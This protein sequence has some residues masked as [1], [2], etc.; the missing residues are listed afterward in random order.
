MPSDHLQP[1]AMDYDV[2]VV[3]AGFGGMYMLHRLREQGFSVRV[4][5]AGTGV[6]GT[7]YWN[8]YPGARC[9]VE[10]LAYQYNFS[11]DLRQ[12]WQWTERYATQQEILR[13]ANHVADRFDLS[14]HMQFETRILSARYADDSNGW[15]LETEHGDRFSAR[16]VVTA[17]GCL[18]AARIPDFPGLED[19]RGEWYHTGWWPHEEVDF[20]GKRVGIIGTGSSA[21]QSIPVIA[22][23]AETLTV[24]QR[25][26]NFSVPAQNV[27]LSADQRATGSQHD[28]RPTHQIDFGEALL[29]QL[30]SARAASPAER[31]Q[32]YETY[33][34]QGGPGFMI[35][36][37]DLLF[38]K[39]ANDTAAEFVRRKIRQIV[40]D[41]AVAEMLC[42]TDHPI[43]TK[44]ICVDTEYYATYN[45]DNVKLVDVRKA[46]IQEI[47]P[48]GLRTAEAEYE[49]DALVFATGFDAMTGPL[50]RM[51]IHGSNG[52]SLARKWADG[53]KSYLG[54]AMAGF[55]NLFTITGPGS[56]SVLSN[57]INSIE[58]HVDWIMA[59]LTRMRER[60]CDRIEALQAAEDTWVAHVN[61]VAERTLFPQAN[62][63]Y[64]G[65]NIPG[66]PRVFMPYVGGI[67][68]YQRRCD[69]V[70]A[71]NYEGFELS[72]AHGA[73]A[74]ID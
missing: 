43:G 31:E 10:S 2:I 9:D 64:M 37:G 66:K 7:W 11:A 46:P 62:S 60:G 18:S 3:G 53:P 23:Q 34:Q 15:V 14:R 19:Y 38:D 73:A 25:T 21:I 4:F 51:D 69:E 48:A 68:T 74:A 39:A 47:T 36:F 13:Y 22:R 44:R 12:E 52:R 50:L 61:E 27:P 33:W 35:A 63:W 30:G 17:V 1:L 20:R 72:S 54:L 45:R 5:E 56:P 57:M 29:D 59:C 70:A 40:N 58:Q 49:L 42:P 65:A 6:G 41:P 55:P 28:Q 32:R 71:R 67:H 8:R 26:P 24:F 16:Y